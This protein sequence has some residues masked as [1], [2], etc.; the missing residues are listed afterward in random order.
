MR[1]LRVALLVFVQF[2]STLQDARAFDTDQ[3][4]N[5][6]QGC[7]ELDQRLNMNLDGRESFA[8]T[9][10]IAYFLGFRDSSSLSSGPRFCVPREV[11][12][13]SIIAFYVKWADR[14][15]SEWKMPVF[16]TVGRALVEKFPCHSM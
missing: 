9:F 5:F 15:V 16:A 6:I 4:K 1:A 12:L 13:K 10:C 7:R 8:E 14:N 3:S 2:L 11:P